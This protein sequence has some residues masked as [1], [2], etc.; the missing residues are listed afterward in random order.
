MH[1]PHDGDD[2]TGWWAG[3]YRV[4]RDEHG[5]KMGQGEV[6]KRTKSESESESDS[7]SHKA[8]LVI[9]QMKR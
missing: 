2:S 4:I 3:P 6:Q 5:L 8:R 7:L 9:V 1:V